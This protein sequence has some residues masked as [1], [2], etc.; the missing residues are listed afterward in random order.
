MRTAL[1]VCLLSIACAIGAQAQWLKVVGKDEITGKASIDFEVKSQLPQHSMMFSL[2]PTTDKLRVGVDARFQVRADEAA[3]EA[4]ESWT[5]TRARIDGVVTNVSWIIVG[6]LDDTL[7]T[8]SLEDGE[9]IRSARKE[10]VL[11]IRE[12]GGH[13]HVLHFNLNGPLPDCPK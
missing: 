12:F 5:T 4:G 2:C 10:V 8:W 11:E 6:D 3:V 9:K 7:F 13:V 1:A